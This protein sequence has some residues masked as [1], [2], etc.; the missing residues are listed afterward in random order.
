MISSTCDTN[1]QIGWLSEASLWIEVDDS[2]HTNHCRL[3]FFRDIMGARATLMSI[4]D[5]NAYPGINHAQASSQCNY[6]DLPN[7]KQCIP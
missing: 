6:P 4:L 3:Y 1:V 7:P 5:T 2:N